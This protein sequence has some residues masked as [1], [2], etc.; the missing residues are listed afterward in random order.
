M[1][2][3]FD[4]CKRLQKKSQD[5]LASVFETWA[6]IITRCSVCSVIVSIILLFYVGYGVKWEQKFGWDEF[7]WAPEVSIV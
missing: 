6:N 2:K 7:E 5:G 3:M 4:S 1:A